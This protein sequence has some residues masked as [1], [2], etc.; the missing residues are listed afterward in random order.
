METPR[1][2]AEGHGIGHDPRDAH[3][4]QKAQGLLCLPALGARL[5]EDKG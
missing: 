3:A 2:C 1:T 5:K 4:V